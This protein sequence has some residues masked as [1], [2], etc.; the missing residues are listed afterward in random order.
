VGV[1]SAMLAHV[2]QTAR[3]SGASGVRAQVA[4]GNREA[5]NFFEAHRMVAH[6]IT[7]S[8]SLV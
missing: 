4:P 8:R 1:G 2:L 3:S 6:S 5:K 7:V